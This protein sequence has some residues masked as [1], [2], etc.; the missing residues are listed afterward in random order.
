MVNFS[1][2]VFTQYCLSQEKVF[3]FRSGVSSIE[4]YIKYTVAFLLLLI[5]TLLTLFLNLAA[6]LTFLS[7]NRLRSSVCYFLIFVQSILDLVLGTLTMMLTFWQNFQAVFMLEFNCMLY[8]VERMVHYV[9]IGS[10]V[11][12][13]SCMNIERFLGI[14]YPMHHRTE[15]TKTRLLA[16]VLTGCFLSLLICTISNLIEST[17]MLRELFASVCLLHFIGTV[18]V[19]VKIYFMGRKSLSR[20]GGLKLRHHRITPMINKGQDLTNKSSTPVEYTNENSSQVKKTTSKSEDFEDKNLS[21]R[22][23]SLITSKARSSSKR[24]EDGRRNRV[25]KFF[26]RKNCEIDEHEL[27]SNYTSQVEA[28][29]RKNLLHNIK[30]ANSCR[31]VVIFSLMTFALPPLII[32]LQPIHLGQHFKEVALLCNVIYFSNSFMNCVIFFW[33]V[34]IL[35][36]EAKLFFRRLWLTLSNKK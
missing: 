15:V 12:V 26:H 30:L 1:L 28:C 13:L 25:C 21:Y 6:I 7:S 4:M 32:G 36:N 9:L 11:S 2:N 35:K 34:A 31:L 16:F 24:Q 22:P 29:A 20:K 17:S 18:I 8:H 3:T 5:I 23:A 14:V 33:R 19:Y 10:S 27:M